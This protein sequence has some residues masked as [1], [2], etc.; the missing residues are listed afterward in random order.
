MFAS[1]YAKR[2][3]TALG[4][5]CGAKDDHGLTNLMHNPWSECYRVR[6]IHNRLYDLD[7]LA[8]GIDVIKPKRNWVGP[9]HDYS[10]DPACIIAGMRN[11]TIFR[12]V[13]ARAVS[14]MRRCKNAD[15]YRIAL[16]EEA[17]ALH[18]RCEGLLK[19]DEIPTMLRWI[20]QH[21]PYR[22][23]ADR[24]KEKRHREGRSRQIY[25]APTRKNEQETYRLFSLGQTLNQIADAL[26]VVVRTVKRYLRK[27]RMELG[28]GVAPLR[29]NSPGNEPG[30]PPIL[31]S[32]VVEMAPDA[33]PA[34][35]AVPNPPQ[36][37]AVGQFAVLKI[38]VSR[39]PSRIAQANSWRNPPRPSG[40]DFVPASRRGLH[41]NRNYS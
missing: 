7:E 6:E 1:A 17:M 4:V 19:S 41:P 34:A 8:A 18:K 37:V 9:K 38:V 3:Q 12:T 15:Q 11:E 28:I 14:I 10:E 25:L 33:S 23:R 35:T 36:G 32:E 13:L 27:V 20:E 24:R 5:A 29:D 22:S 30:S 2:V 16:E 21:C 39:T 31:I 26:G 40:R